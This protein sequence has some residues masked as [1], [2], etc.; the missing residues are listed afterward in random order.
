MADDE[1]Q[2]T[3]A[4]KLSIATYFITSAPT[5]EV[6]EVLKDV[7]ALVN[8]SSVL[9]NEKITKIM[10][11]YNTQRLTTATAPNGED[12]MV[13]T[14]GQVDSSSYL[15]PATGKVLKF[16]HLNQTFTGETDQKQVLSE[17][18]NAYRAAIEHLVKAYTE[19]NYKA[20]KCTF[21]VYG[22]DDGAITVC[23]SAK[24]TRL[25]SYWT[26]GITAVYKL[27]VL[28]H[29]HTDLQGNI[30]INVHYFEDGNVQL[31]T[32]LNKHAR[33]DIT[34]PASTAK[35]VVSAIEKI[36][37]DF[38]NNLEELYV[39]MHTQ[40]FKAMRRF[41]PISGQYMKWDSSVHGL[42]DEISQ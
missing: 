41:L 36:E 6:N 4:Q 22:A 35:V 15:D 31:H 14:Y 3:P 10:H 26:G 42:A 33:V 37:T 23:F 20:K 25:T 7:K 2:A 29:G 27:N 18:I 34:E 30:K 9:T 39:N 12:V 24:N 28:K 16:D 5:G 38:Y 17:N 1:P 8:D 13:S 40:T 32:D 11:D 19:N 21:A